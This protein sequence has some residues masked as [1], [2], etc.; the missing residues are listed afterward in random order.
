MP[1]DGLKQI[2]VAR[3]GQLGPG[4]SKRPTPQMPATVLQ[5]ATEAPID[6]C[7]ALLPPDRSRL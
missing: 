1:L 2:D 6:V 7:R 4:I 5:L 3:A